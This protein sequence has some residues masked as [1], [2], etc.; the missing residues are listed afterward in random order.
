MNQLKLNNIFKGFDEAINKINDFIKNIKENIDFDNMNFD[1]YEILDY[2]EYCE[3]TLLPNILQNLKYEELKDILKDYDFGFYI[4][5]V[6]ADQKY[7]VIV[8]I[9]YSAKQN[10]ISK[11]LKDK[12]KNYFIDYFNNNYTVNISFE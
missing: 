3:E 5:D 12:V 6:D 11:D 9:L 2:P 8:I 1:I 10:N 4:S 7:I